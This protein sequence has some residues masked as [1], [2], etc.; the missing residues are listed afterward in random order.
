MGGAPP[1]PLGSGVPGEAGREG[2]A[3]R[4]GIQPFPSRSEQLGSAQVAEA[5]GAGVPQSY[6]VP[7][8]PVTPLNKIK[9]YPGG[10][11]Q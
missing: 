2:A 11:R 4:G 3:V 9:G 1:S 6:R 5:S 8:T 10:S 7:R